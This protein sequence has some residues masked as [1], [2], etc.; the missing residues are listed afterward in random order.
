MNFNLSEK[1][2]IWTEDIKNQNTHGEFFW[3]EDVKKFIR[4]LKRKLFV[5]EKEMAPKIKGHDWANGYSC[6]CHDFRT[7]IIDELAGDK[8]L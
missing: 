3:E 6:A 7:L 8:L 4:K 1:R 2:E 5:E